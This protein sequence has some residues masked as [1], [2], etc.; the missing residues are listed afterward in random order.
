MK[1]VITNLCVSRLEI[2]DEEDGDVR[3]YVHGKEVIPVKI[4]GN[5]V[6]LK[7]LAL[8]ND[9]L[10]LEF[11]Y[12]KRNELLPPMHVKI[13]KKPSD[14]HRGIAFQIQEHLKK[15]RESIIDMHHTL[16]FS[17]AHDH[18]QVRVIDSYSA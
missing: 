15:N 2:K 17:D 5:D 3:D 16:G 9:L 6:L 10:F 7:T 8:L 4:M 14:I 12:F 1:E 18:L 11:G 13:V